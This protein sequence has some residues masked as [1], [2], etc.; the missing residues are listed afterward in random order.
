MLPWTGV[1]AWMNEL[2]LFIWAREISEENQKLRQTDEANR[3]K[4]MILEAQA[5][6]LNQVRPVDSNQLRVAYRF[7]FVFFMIAPKDWEA[8]LNQQQSE[9]LDKQMVTSEAREKL[10]SLSCQFDEVFGKYFC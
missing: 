5:V 8:K 2:L 10:K 4:I 1:L 6:K 7:G 3:E 9:M